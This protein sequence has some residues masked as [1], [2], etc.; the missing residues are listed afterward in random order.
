MQQ[1]DAEK[2][3]RAATRELLPTDAQALRLFARFNEDAGPNGHQF[4]RDESLQYAAGLAK[5]ENLTDSLH[6]LN[7]LSDRLETASNA[8]LANTENP[9]LIA[10]LRPWILQAKLAAQ[11]GRNVAGMRANAR[12]FMLKYKAARSIRKQMFDLE[13]SDVRHPQ[14]PGIKVGSKWFIPTLDAL[15]AKT[16]TAYNEAKNAQLDINADYQPYHLASTVAQLANQPLEIKGNTI[17]V[18]PA[19]EVI[20]WKAGETLTISS[21]IEFTLQGLDFDLSTPNI[22]KDFSLEV[23]NNGK[24]IEV[25]LLHYKPEDTTVHTGNELAGMKGKALR[26]TNCSGTDL[27]LRLKRF[28]FVKK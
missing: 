17:S 6:F 23:G 8:L 15:F 3:W 20:T 21:D 5:A 28:A 13:N 18:R 12:D 27:T 25:S 2:Q 4:R 24:W 7:K 22:A 26:L 1:Y 19:L 16:V 11:Y 14:M 9:R 10:E